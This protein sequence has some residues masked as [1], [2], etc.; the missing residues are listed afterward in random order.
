MVVFESTS[1]LFELELRYYKGFVSIAAAGVP[2]QA[3]GS[4][5]RVIR[6][7]TLDRNALTSALG[8]MIS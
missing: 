4:L 2:G 8:S 5:A 6:Q 7:D 1:L 3:S